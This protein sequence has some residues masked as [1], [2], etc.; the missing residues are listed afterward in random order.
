MIIGRTAAFGFTANEILLIIHKFLIL[1][2]TIVFLHN[3]LLDY[4]TETVGSAAAK[5]IF[6]LPTAMLGY[7][8]TSAID[9]GRARRY[10]K[11]NNI[12][13]T[14]ATIKNSG[15]VDKMES[16]QD[17]LE[18]RGYTGTKRG[19]QNYNILAEAIEGVARAKARD[20]FAHNTAEKR[21]EPILLSD[22][23]KW[24]PRDYKDEL[25]N[26]PHFQKVYQEYLQQQIDQENKGIQ[27]GIE[28]EQRNF[29]NQ[30]GRITA[31]AN[32]FD[33]LRK[34]IEWF[35]F[36]GKEGMNGGLP[37]GWTIDG[38]TATNNAGEVLHLREDSQ[39]KKF[40]AKEDD[41]NSAKW[42]A[43]MKEMDAELTKAKAAKQAGDT[44]TFN[45]ILDRIIKQRESMVSQLG[46]YLGADSVYDLNTIGS[47]AKLG[48]DRQT[49]I[50][51]QQ[52]YGSAAEDLIQKIV[53]TDNR[54]SRNL[55]AAELSAR[56]LPVDVAFTE[57]GDDVKG[58]E[59]PQDFVAVHKSQ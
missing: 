42:Q 55:T 33:G 4:K 47:A 28:N 13:D 51:L 50:A 32:A 12:S 2:L 34:D 17:I 35:G 9:D 27:Q 3:F 25:I 58:F 14:T 26:N 24:K 22:A 48:Q 41:A 40:W 46:R 49:L 7:D 20:T 44:A 10:D 43:K 38:N 56:G 30:T 23:V 59:K 8:L 15:D 11:N 21:N 54:I 31:D 6:S 18:K 37:K 53:Y 57:K 5:I 52:K 16:W 36:D 19:V 39:G 1:A 45:S 29:A